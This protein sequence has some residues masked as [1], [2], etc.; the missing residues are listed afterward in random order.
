[1]TAAGS[2][3]DPS[4]GLPLQR[5]PAAPPKHSPFRSLKVKFMMGSSEWG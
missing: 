5:F 1:M 3:L 4:H 2:W